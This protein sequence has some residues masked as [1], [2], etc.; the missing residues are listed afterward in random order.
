MNE[1]KIQSHLVSGKGE[2]E[3]CR[4]SQLNESAIG[5]RESGRKSGNE[6]Q[7]LRQSSDTE[8]SRLV[9][10]STS[11]RPE[12]NPLVNGRTIN[13]WQF[14]DFFTIIGLG[15]AFLSILRVFL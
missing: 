5:L 15:L 14:L 9:P 13:S 2:A 7:T 12:T 4:S 6:S 3:R 1:R 8:P 11:P 10:T